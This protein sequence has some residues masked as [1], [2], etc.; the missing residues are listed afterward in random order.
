MSDDTLIRLAIEYWKLIRALE[1]AIER[2]PVEHATKTAAQARYSSRRL[3]AILAEAGIHLVTF[4]G[5]LFEPNIAAT[6]V[7]SDEIERDVQ[8]VVVATIEPAVMR[9]MAVLALGKVVVAPVGGGPD[10]SRN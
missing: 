3:T 1:R 5:T 4:D 10:A 7:N 2:L 8:V 6:A 9:D